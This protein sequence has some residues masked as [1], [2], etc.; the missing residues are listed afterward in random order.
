MLSA[1][2]V[3]KM[4]CLEDAIGEYWEAAFREGRFKNSHSK[5]AIEG[6]GKIRAAVELRVLA[7]REACIL[8]CEAEKVGQGIEPSQL[9]EGDQA[10]NTA[11][12][13]VVLAIRVRSNVP[14]SGGA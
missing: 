4:N 7:E 2:E 13:H 11:I 3:E 1:E 14:T 8:A 12:D 9:C 6:L 5:D 10:Y